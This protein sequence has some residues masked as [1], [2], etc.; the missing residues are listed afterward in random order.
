MI[1]DLDDGFLVSFVFTL[2]LFVVCGDTF[3]VIIR[4]E[5]RVA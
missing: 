3:W 5:S 4:N 2:L 1:D